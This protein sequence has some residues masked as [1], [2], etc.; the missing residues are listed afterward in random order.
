[1]IV[2]SA[3]VPRLTRVAAAV[4]LTVANVV[5]IAVKLVFG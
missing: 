1:M 4:P 2:S 3:F 5:V